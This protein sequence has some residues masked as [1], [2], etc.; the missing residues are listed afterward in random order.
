MKRNITITAITILLSLAIVNFLAS[1]HFARID[2]T[3]NKEYTLAPSTKKILHD[4]KDVVTLRMYFTE[5]MPPQISALKRL[6]DDTVDEFRSYSGQNVRVEYVDPSSSDEAQREALVAKVTPVQ[7]NVQDNNKVEVA[8][9]YLGIGVMKGDKREVIPVVINPQNLEY[10]LV[11]RIVK[12][13]SD[14]LPTVA[15]WGPQ[16]TE[17][18]G[19]LSGQ[20][21]LILRKELS[22]RYTI[23]DVNPKLLDLDP[24]KI[25]ALMVVAPHAVTEDQ[26]RVIDTYVMNGGQVIALIDTVAV[27]TQMQ[28]MSQ[29]SGLESLLTHYGITIKNDLVMDRSNA[30]ALFMGGV[31]NYQIPYP[32][33]VKLLTQDIDS[34]SRIVSG[35][36]GIV[37]PWTSSLDVSKAPAEGVT[38]KVLAR[39][40]DFA[41]VQNFD[42]GYKLDP[43]TAG[44]S[45][46]EGGGKSYTLI[47]SAEGRLPSYFEKS[48]VADAKARVLVVGTSRVAQDQFVHQFPQDKTMLL[49][50][51]DVMSIGDQ[52]IDVRSRS[53][54]GHPIEDLSDLAENIIKYAN[55]AGGVILIAVMAIVVVTYRRGRR[56]SLQAMYHHS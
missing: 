18:Q 27:S 35:L 10:D 46:Q 38:L 4:L 25:S 24:E 34:E 8:K 21:Y 32:F 54:L 49:N 41:K 22:E 7:L 40:T 1:R 28:A 51:V 11:S 56:R 16:L 12:L 6:V 42:A 36:D 43:D 23:V 30:N 55:I 48:K 39:T 13:T 45:M 20:G 26:Q 52:L 19:A 29:T 37:L 53:Q 2:L 15:W 33:W 47:A 17:E 31:V 50:A 9:I 44:K 14:K 5:N 3:R